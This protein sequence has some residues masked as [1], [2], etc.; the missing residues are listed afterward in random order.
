[1]S[2]EK[3][4]ILLEASGIYEGPNTRG[5]RVLDAE[6]LSLENIPNAEVPISQKAGYSGAPPAATIPLLL[7]SQLASLARCVTHVIGLT[8]TSRVIFLD[9]KSWICSVDLETLHKHS[10]SYTRHFFVPYDWF[11]G[12]RDIIGAAAQRNIV[13]ARNDE[14]GIIKRGLDY[15]ETVDVDIGR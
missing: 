15:A 9:H 12:M 4:R 3:F 13:L 10:V 6:A 1:M 5:L 7:G 2:A 14:I 11:S 8:S